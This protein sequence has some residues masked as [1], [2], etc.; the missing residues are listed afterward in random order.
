ML[1]GYRPELLADRLGLRPLPEER[2]TLVD[3]RDLD[4]PEEEYLAA[5]AIRRRSVADVEP[6]DG[7]I[8]LHVDLDVVDAGALPGLRIPAAGRGPSAD[9]LL[10]ALGRIA[11]T[12]RVAALDVACTWD[13]AVPDP[14]GARRRLLDQV[15]GVGVRGGGAA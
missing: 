1:L 6:P 12:G 3:A 5:A 7:P 4:P 10:A 11:A 13:P 15:M 9:D 2:V 14:A 8:L